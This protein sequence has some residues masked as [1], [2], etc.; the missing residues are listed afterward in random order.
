MKSLIKNIII[1][2]LLSLGSFGCFDFTKYD[3]P[4]VPE[5]LYIPPIN[6]KLAAV[7]G[8]IAAVNDFA[9][10]ISVTKG[11]NIADSRSGLDMDFTDTNPYTNAYDSKYIGP[12]PLTIPDWP[13]DASDWV[14]GIQKQGQFIIYD[15]FLDVTTNTNFTVARSNRV[16]SMGF[17][18]K[19]W[20]VPGGGRYG[21]IDK[22]PVEVM[23]TSVG[24][25]Y[26]DLKREVMVPGGCNYYDPAAV[27]DKTSCEDL[28]NTGEY[29]WFPLVPPG[30]CSF[31]DFYDQASC[32]D[33]GACDDTAYSTKDDCVGGGGTWEK[34]VVCDLTS[35][36]SY[37]TQVDCENEG[38]IW[39]DTPSRCIKYPFETT[40][41]GSSLGPLSGFPPI[42]NEITWT[43][44]GLCSKFSSQTGNLTKPQK[45]SAIK[46][47]QE[48]CDNPVYG[49]EWNKAAGSPQNDL[50]LQ[51]VYEGTFN[52]SF[53]DKLT[54]Q[55]ITDMEVYFGLFFY[56][57]SEFEISGVGNIISENFAG[58]VVINGQSY[59][60]QN[61]W[62]S[63][64]SEYYG[65]TEICPG[66]CK[67]TDAMGWDPILCVE[68]QGDWDYAKNV[69]TLSDY[70]ESECID[71]GGTYE[72]VTQCKK[73]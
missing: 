68:Y 16:A 58:W 41:D 6:E 63:S 3:D 2:V 44:S 5:E 23:V 24:T 55:Q 34:Y 59:Y 29:W 53:T 60:Y 13:H 71:Y 14:D 9:R 28:G 31:P 46:S 21:R 36:P 52:V 45:L 69:C 22:N 37:A 72:Q 20:K 50:Y 65:E 73:K 7:T 33:P 26:V 56:E 25:V 64:A 70:L 39:I 61:P 40:C 49:R 62:L 8:V 18:L 10:S 15:G 48:A 54:G 1:I 4:G 51:G 43:G 57:F 47:E 38:Y 12:T 17:A 32:L 19:N 42:M 11:A 30:S 66:K 27:T 67:F 35:N